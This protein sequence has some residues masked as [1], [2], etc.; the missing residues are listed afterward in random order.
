MGIFSD[1]LQTPQSTTNQLD[2]PPT[3]P[4][5][6]Y[7]PTAEITP[8]ARRKM[9]EE[10]AVLEAMTQSSLPVS[11]YLGPTGFPNWVSTPYTMPDP[12]DD[13]FQFGPRAPRGFGMEMAGNRYEGGFAME[14]FPS[15]DEIISSMEAMEGG[16]MD[17]GF[18]FLDDMGLFDVPL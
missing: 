16:G 1:F 11:P 6:L 2:E 13:S 5:L 9:E 3:K 12:R 4:Q 7:H 14:E 17:G 10:R 15:L 18:G 8:E